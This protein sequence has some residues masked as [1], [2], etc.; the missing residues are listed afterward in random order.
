MKRRQANK[1][2]KAARAGYYRCWKYRTVKA[3]AVKVAGHA[4]SDRFLAEVIMLGMIIRNANRL[5]ASLVS[6]DGAI[7]TTTGKM[8][9][10]N[11][12]LG[13]VLGLDA[14]TNEELAA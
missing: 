3:A 5:A 14:E 4:V 1:I 13:E 2:V 11:K 6:L 8:K 12:V 9:R 10:F 7:E